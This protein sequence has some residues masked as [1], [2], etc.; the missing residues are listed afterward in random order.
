MLSLE[1]PAPVTKRGTKWYATP[2][3][4]QPDRQKIEQLTRIRYQ[5][6]EQMG[7]YMESQECLMAFLARALDDPDPTP[8]GKCAVCQ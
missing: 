2:V 4:Y 7:E 3:F 5:E 1:S 6:Q 8:C